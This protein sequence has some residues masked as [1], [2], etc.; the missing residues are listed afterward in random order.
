M[1]NLFMF[2][3]VEEKYNVVDS[4][5]NDL[6]LSFNEEVL[7]DVLPF[8]PTK[9]LSQIDFEISKIDLSFD[10]IDSDSESSS[11]KTIDNIVNDNQ[12]P[13]LGLHNLSIFKMNK[14]LNDSGLELSTSLSVVDTDD[15][16]ISVAANEQLLHENSEEIPENPK[17]IVMSVR[18]KN[19]KAIGSY[20]KPSRPCFIC[21]KMQARLKQY[22]LSIHKEHPLVKPLLKLNVKE[23]NRQL[24]LLRKQ[25]I[26]LNNE[27]A[28]S[29]GQDLMRERL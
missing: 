5:E 4:K 11:N 16:M 27:K 26:R 19:N 18:E 28:I 29:M 17:R 7:S 1:R 25:G 10:E 6:N 21:R 13:L 2:D 14:P 22:I 3:I 23:Q 8:Y 15:S 24:C 12:E 9:D 20:K